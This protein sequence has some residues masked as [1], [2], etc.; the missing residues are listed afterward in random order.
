MNKITHFPQNVV[1]LVDLASSPH[2]VDESDGTLVF[3]LV[4]PLLQNG[5]VI[6]LSFK[7]AETV[8]TSFLNRAI[9]DLYQQIS[10]EAIE[11]QLHFVDVDEEDLARIERVQTF[12]NEFYQDPEGVQAVRDRALADFL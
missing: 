10:A 4:L 6:S 11:Q 1:Q 12:A 9:G 2:L 3:Q 8:T 5:E 7:D